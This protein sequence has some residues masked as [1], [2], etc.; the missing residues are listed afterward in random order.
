[1]TLQEIFEQLSMGEFSQLSIGRAD[2]G[3]IDESNWSNVLGHVNLGLTR[4]YTRFNLKERRLQFPLQAGSDTYQ[5]NVHDILKVEKVLTDDDVELPL[6][7]ASNPYSCM[8]KSMHTLV[9][10]AAISDQ[11]SGLPDDLKTTNLM[12]VY[13]ANHPKLVIGNLVNG[14]EAVTIEL[15]ESHLEALLY[16]VASRVNNPIG[17]TNE[18]H[19]GNSYATKF[20]LA[21]Q[22]LEGAGLQ[23]DTTATNTKL[24]QKGFV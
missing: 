9:V 17:M 16:F 14:P 8:M 5:L 20:E 19:A 7:D 1:M 23:V 3:V 12:V 22:E 11:V 4:L 18:F 2:Q 24:S 10:P 13:R 15:P 6:N 21:C